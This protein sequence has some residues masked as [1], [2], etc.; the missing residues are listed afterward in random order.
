MV[1]KFRVLFNGANTGRKSGES[2]KT[3]KN[4]AISAGF[5]IH[6]VDVVWIAL[7]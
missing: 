4:P 6:T 5:Q 1:C 2:M 7:C 3:S